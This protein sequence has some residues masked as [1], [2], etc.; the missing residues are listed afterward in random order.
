MC[1]RSFVDFEDD[2]NLLI[3]RKISTLE[4]MIM[5]VMVGVICAVVAVIYGS[6]LLFMYYKLRFSQTQRENTVFVTNSQLYPDDFGI[7]TK[8]KEEK[9]EITWASYDSVKW[10]EQMRKVVITLT[11][12]IAIHLYFNGT[13]FSS[14][15]SCLACDD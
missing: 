6:T 1:Y 2:F 4:M 8:K 9:M 11:I 15:H 7:Q 3:I 12:G 5:I 10:F 13:L 14:L